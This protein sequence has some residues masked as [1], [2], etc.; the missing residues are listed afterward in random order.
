VALTLMACAV[1][2]VPNPTWSQD[3]LMEPA[4][5]PPPERTEALALPEAVLQ[6]LQQNLEITVSRQNRDIRLTDILFEQAKFDPT[7]QLSGRYDRTVQPLNRPI[8]GFGTGPVL[9]EPQAFDQNQTIVN[10]GLTQ[11]L[12]TGANY[13][14]TFNPQRT[15]VAG[16][17]TF[18]F[19]A[20]Y[21][22]G[23]I[24]NLTQPL[25]RDFGP[26]I[27]KT[28]I[29]IARNNA[30]VQ[31][32]AF[33]DQVL[34]VIADVEQAYWELV[35]ARENLSVAMA[36]HKAAQELLASNQAKAKAG[37]MAVVDVLQAEAAVA[38][39]VEEIL[40]REKAIRDQEDQL[41]R[42][43]N[44]GE[45]LLRQDV[46]VTPTDEPVQ[47]LQPLSLEEALDTAIAKRPEVLQAEKNI[48]SSKLNV[49]F[50]KN[51]L[52]PGL[53]FQ[54][55]MGLAGLGDDT[56]DMLDRNFGGNFYN[57][58]AGLVLSYPLGNRSAWS[59]YTKR[60]LEA[61]NAQASLQSA[62]QQV[63]VD[64]RE[65]VRRVQTDFRRIET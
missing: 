42:L 38:S 54:G 34:R 43:L 40:I 13:D 15:F 29:R 9:T 63:I 53:S 65:A 3:A 5:P 61:R 50:S 4:L 56:L 6:A 10:L 17:T 19:N 48:D 8:F 1:L 21:T 11:K 20:A 32:H 30:E 52:L 2:L 51:Q 45:V 25:L 58:G 44:P 35:F 36:A 41:R 22:S 23:L 31:G 37:I 62:R 7:V 18:L 26:D 27:N 33:L 46:R 47:V 60:Q 12:T 49:K 28:L 16:P 55:T 24:L 64:V 59:Q 14:L 57:W 39:R